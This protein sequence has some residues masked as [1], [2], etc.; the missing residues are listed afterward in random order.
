MQ[1]FYNSPKEVFSM[2]YC[3]NND[4]ESFFFIFK[5]SIFF[6]YL[7]IIISIFFIDHVTT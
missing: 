4:K 5:F 6:I 1:K 7:F 2:P 3:H